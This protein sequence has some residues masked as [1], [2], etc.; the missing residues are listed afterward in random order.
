[1][2]ANVYVSIFPLSNRRIGKTV[3]DQIKIVTTVP[4]VLTRTSTPAPMSGFGGSPRAKVKARRISSGG[5]RRPGRAPTADR[6]PLVST[7]TG[8]RPLIKGSLSFYSRHLY[9][10]RSLRLT[11]SDRSSCSM[12]RVSLHLTVASV[13]V[14]KSS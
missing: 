12:S 14:P 8:G 2:K 3:D 9:A 5:R 7:A 13:N 4:S 10:L 11:F 6:T 1:M